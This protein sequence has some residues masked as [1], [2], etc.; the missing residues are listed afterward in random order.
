[1]TEGIKEVWVRAWENEK[2]TGS[3]LSSSVGLHV[4]CDLA[5][6]MAASGPMFLPKT[7]LIGIV[8]K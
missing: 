7:F 3:L 1:M 5:R 2:D 6:F 4:G 8:N